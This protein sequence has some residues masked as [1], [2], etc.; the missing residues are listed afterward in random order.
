MVENVRVRFCD[1]FNKIEWPTRLSGRFAIHAHY[2][3]LI[4]SLHH[5][6]HMLE[7]AIQC[8]GTSSH[9]FLNVWE[10]VEELESGCVLFATFIRNIGAYEFNLTFI[11]FEHVV[12]TSSSS[13]KKN[14][15]WDQIDEQR[16]QVYKE[17]GKLW[18]W[19]FRGDLS[20]QSAPARI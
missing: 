12:R 7:T 18:K 13:G 4:I 10:V 6:S 19:I 15:S 8:M 2:F 3:K 9:M 17:E 16:L 5:S 11:F 20:P 1:F 14:I